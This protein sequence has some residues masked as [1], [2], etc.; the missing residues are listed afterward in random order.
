MEFIDR[1]N[2]I[3]GAA[4]AVL[5]AVFGVYWYLF[6]G[7][8]VLNI[9]DWITGWYRSRKLHKESSY[10]GLMGIIKK[11]GYWVIVAVSFMLPAMFINFF[12]DTFGI[13]I[14]EIMFLG[15]F[16]LCTLIVNEIRSILENLVECGYSVPEVLVKGLAITDEMLKK[17]EKLPEEKK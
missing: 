16:T 2:L 13:R 4:V 15:W 17:A 7:Y 5:S 6:A 11:L 9:L 14:D 3:V 1:Y 10:V 8:L 12:E